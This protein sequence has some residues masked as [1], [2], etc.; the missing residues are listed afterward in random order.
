MRQCAPL[1]FLALAVSPA[2]GQSVISARSGLINYSE[3]D[4]LV[5]G[6]PLQRK[7]GLYTSLKEGSDLVTRSGRAEV[8]LTPNTYLRVGEESGIHM[9][10]ADLGDTRLELLGGSAML[11]SIAAPG[12]TPVSI[13]VRSADVRFVKPGKFRLDT[14]PPQLRVYEGEAEVTTDG[15]T[16]TVAPDQ[17][18]PL[19][20][21]TI[22]RRF[23]EGSDNLLDL[24]SDERHSLIASNLIDASNI[25]D[26]LLDSDTMMPGD[27]AYLGYVP[28]ASY[29]PLIGRPYTGP[30]VVGGYPSYGYSPYGYSPYSIYSPYSA[31][32]I[33]GGLY[34]GRGYG[35]IYSGSIRPGGLGGFSSGLG[36]LRPG[37]GGI[38]AGPTAIRS[39]VPTAPRPITVGPRPV[40]GARIGGGRR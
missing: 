27:S 16:V 31:F 25:G 9:V 4:V 8:L 28:L 26:P 30:I 32:V 1:L 40:G 20:G 10:S 24:W 37:F 39:L 22:V 2:F 15:K 14:E 3:G 23:T 18:L 38:S 7:F 29:P 36:G 12:T 35:S 17:L 6:Q 5:N 19:D 33:Y 21:A 34:G 13:T 11:D